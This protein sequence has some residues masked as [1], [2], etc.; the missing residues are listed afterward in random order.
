[1][2]NIGLEV[3]LTH[4]CDISFVE[5]GEKKNMMSVDLWETCHTGS[6]CAAVTR[7]RTHSG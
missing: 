5:M 7:T 2:N 4:P 1:M 6:L 3:L